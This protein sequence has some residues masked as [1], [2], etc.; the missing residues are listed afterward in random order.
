M[1][2]SA[3][4][5]LQPRALQQSEELHRRV[6]AFASEH[7]S[8]AGQ[9]ETF[10]DL[11]I[12]IA[13]YQ[14]QEAPGMAR[15][16]KRVPRSIEDIPAVPTEVFRLTRV[17]TF[18]TELDRARFQTSGTTKRETGVHPARTLETY[19]HLALLLAERS[20]FRNLSRAPVVIG[21]AEARTGPIPSSSLTY[22]MELFMRRF[23]GRRLSTEPVRTEK[24]ERGERFFVRM[25]GVDVEGL[26][27][28][29]RVAA[30]REEPLVVLGTSF[31]FA[32]LLEALDGEIL[33]SSAEVRIM[34][35]GGFK[36]RVR[37]IPEARLREHIAATFGAGPSAVL[38]EYGMTELTSQLYES[39][40]EDAIGAQGDRGSAS[41]WFPQI[42]RPDVFYAPPWLRVRA[43]DPSTHRRVP[44][45][46]VGVAHCIDLGNID[47][48]I[49]VLTEDRIREIDGGVELCGR[50][51]SAPPRGCSLTY[52]DLL[53]GDGP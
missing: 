9:S 14:F 37:E 34:I 11:A 15:L 32:A 23:D 29:I 47:S 53:R 8:G 5:T 51:P 1:R 19:D 42:G 21:L 43:V 13:E 26:E 35:T 25:G 16:A 3:E 41:P 49:A 22:M 4:Q 17:A 30:H 10:E 31:A 18:P 48:H 28:A 44:P 50:A 2:K 40:P 46:E 39:W 24:L 6:R 20:L 36:G 7:A 27:R 33:P 38:G 52:E 12:A 45:G